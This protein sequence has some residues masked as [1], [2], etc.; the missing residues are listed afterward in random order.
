ML[1]KWLT[2]VAFKD[3]VVHGLTKTYYVKQNAL[4]N[5]QLMGIGLNKI[6][7]LDEKPFED[8][9]LQPL[10]ALFSKK[11]DKILAFYKELIDVPKVDNL[12]KI[13][14]AEIDPADEYFT[15]AS[16]CLTLNDVRFL[17]DF[18]LN[19]RELFEGSKQSANILM[20][21]LNHFIKANKIF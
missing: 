5:I 11:Y 12:D 6:F 10:N 4:S 15:S 21:D 9:F 19:Y 2:Q 17:Y 1:E 18:M 8:E 20:E 16:L 7:S 3:M 13:F 14:K